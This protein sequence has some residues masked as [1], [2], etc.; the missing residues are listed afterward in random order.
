[1][2]ESSGSAGEVRAEKDGPMARSPDDP[3]LRRTKLTNN[4]IA[5][6]CYPDGAL[7]SRMYLRKRIAGNQSQEAFTNSRSAGGFGARTY[8]GPRLPPNPS[9]HAHR[10][11]GGGGRTRGR[12]FFVRRTAFLADLG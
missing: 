3:M 10:R 4:R 11:D 9:H 12:A 8:G 7:V 2:I 1:M 5:G 6:R